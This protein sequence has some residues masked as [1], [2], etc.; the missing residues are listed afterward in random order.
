M[1]ARVCPGSGVEAHVRRRRRASPGRGGTRCGRGQ[2]AAGRPRP[3]LGRRKGH[4]RAR[5]V[6]LEGGRS[7]LLPRRPSWSVLGR[8]PGVELVGVGGLVLGRRQAEA[9]VADDGEDLGVGELPPALAPQ[10]G[11]PATPLT[12]ADVGATGPVGRGVG[13]AAGTAGAAVV[14]EADLIGEV[15]EALASTRRCTARSPRRPSRCWRG[16]WRSGCRRSAPTA[17]GPSTC[18]GCLVMALTKRNIQTGRSASTGETQTG[19]LRRL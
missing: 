5:D 10:A 16:S 2:P 8:A 3:G 17:S 13:L 9:L 12:P 1:S 15:R 7:H 11:M 19:I 18:L 6:E 4:G 14:D